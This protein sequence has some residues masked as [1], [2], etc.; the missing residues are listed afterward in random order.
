[1]LFENS[2]NTFYNFFFDTTLEDL[3]DDYMPWPRNFNKRALTNDDVQLPAELRLFPGW[4]CRKPFEPSYGY[5]EK[6]MEL[7]R[8]IADSN[9][10][11]ISPLKLTRPAG[12]AFAS[13]TIVGPSA[14][15]PSTAEF[16]VAGASLSG[17]S[18]LATG[19]PTVLCL[20]P[21]IS[22]IFQPTVEQASQSTPKP[23]VACTD[24][25]TEP[26][27]TI[28]LVFQLVRFLTSTTV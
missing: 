9:G 21:S 13:S 20:L 1:M 3:N 2:K 5:L 27:R 11:S 14:A 17:S 25:Q 6:W 12:A 7:V 10:R 15:G 22:T 16:S 18:A 23:A 28:S 24:T 19:V 26:E 8:N 4:E